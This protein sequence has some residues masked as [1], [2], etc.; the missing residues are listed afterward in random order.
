[1]ADKIVD[2]IKQEELCD[3]DERNHVYL[4]CNYPYVNP[5]PDTTYEE[6]PE[7]TTTSLGERPR[8]EPS[9]EELED[10]VDGPDS[11]DYKTPTAVQQRELLKLHRG[12]GHPQ[13]N[14]FGRAL[15]YAGVHRNLIRW[16]VKEL[17]CPVCE[18]R[19]QPAARR[20]AASNVS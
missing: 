5:V 12:L 2:W 8:E 19:V 1:M 7:G 15:K 11:D 13:P 20:P 10:I 6:P 4:S 17:R 9:G 3:F 18:G 14:D 16:A